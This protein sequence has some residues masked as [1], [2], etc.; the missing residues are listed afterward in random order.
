MINCITTKILIFVSGSIKQERVNT[1][2]KGTKPNLSQKKKKGKNT[3]FNSP[4]Y[5]EEGPDHKTVH[6]GAKNV[7]RGGR[8]LNTTFIFFLFTIS[9]KGMFYL[10]FYFVARVTVLNLV[11]ESKWLLRGL[12]YK[13]CK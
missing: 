3:S 12:K 4:V 6:S 13:N 1:I 11:E 10:V 5:P 8:T 9:Y 2:E 7:D